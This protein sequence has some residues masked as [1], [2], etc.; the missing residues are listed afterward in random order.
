MNN[1]KVKVHQG[2][3][4]FEHTKWMDLKVGVSSIGLN[5]YCICLLM[6]LVFVVLF[7]CKFNAM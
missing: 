4:G 3:G 5:T 1:R 7:T 6:S 2:D